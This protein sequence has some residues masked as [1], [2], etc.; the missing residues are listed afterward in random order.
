ML[1]AVLATQACRGEASVAKGSGG[2]SGSGLGADGGSSANA[3]R[4]GSGTGGSGARGGGA[5]SL[6]SGG[7]ISVNMGGQ[8]GEGG[9][10]CGSSELAA[11]RPR[12]NV[13]LV[14]DKS[15]SM[16]ID[17]EFPEGRWAALGAALGSALDEAASRVSFGLELFPFADDPMDT[18]D[19]CETPRDGGVLVG[20]GP[21]DSTVP[22][23]VDAFT[24]YAPAGGTP[25]ADA[26]KLARE[27]LTTGAGKSLEGTSYV[28][29]AT[30]GGPNCNADLACDK[31]SCTINLENTMAETGCGGSCCD[32]MID[33]N[34]AINCLDED[35]TVDEVTAL[36]DAG[37]KTFVVGIP[38]SQFFAGTLD[39][40]AEAGGE[41]NPD[42][43]PSY[44]R[45]TSS[46]GA[47]GLT[48]VLTRITEG[49]ITSCR[50]Q[51]T[52]TPDSPNYEGLLNVVIDGTEIPQMGAD[53]WDVDRSTS[54]PTVVLKGATCEAMETRGAEQVTITYGCPTVI[55]PR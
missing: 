47:E 11:E 5:G 34:G 53:G 12:V 55:V 46:S 6:G 26:L 24:T 20:V 39:K 52:S 40:L 48:E 10:D 54:P 42:A 17:T 18:P 45:V 9:A 13:L 21:G 32:P 51:L 7:S 1:V 38:G 44:F 29:L 30:D 37:I 19:T 25:T 31:D 16:S 4:G 14:I 22:Q 35:R 43:P 49:L 15:S 50:L 23:I 27:Y 2:S 36:A 33:P 41:P 3:G 8:S 28:L